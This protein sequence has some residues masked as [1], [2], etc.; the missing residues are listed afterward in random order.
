LAYFSP[1]VDSA[2]LH[3]PA[4]LDIRDD[5]IAQAK[6]I[7]GS[8]IYLGNDSLDYQ[9]ISA[10]ALKYSD[11]L[12]AVQLAYNN[13]SPS[14][15][16]G[17]GLDGIVKLNGIK[18]KIASYSTCVVT[19][20]G[21]AG[22][23]ILNGAVSDISGNIWDLPVAVTIG[24]SG[25]VD[26]VAT[27][28][29]IGAITAQRG[30][31]SNISTPTYGWI[32]VTNNVAAVVG[33]PVE[34]D[35]QLK[36]RQAISTE[37]PSQTLLQGTNAGVASVTGVSRYKTYENDT[38]EFDY[39]GLP[40]H[41]V[42]VVAEGGSD[43]DIA[44]QIYARKNIGCY[45]NGTTAVDIPDQY[46]VT[47]IRFYKPTYLPIF[48]TL[49]VHALAGYTSATT[50]NIK[51]AI[52]SYLNSLQIGESLT[53]SAVWATAMSATPNLKQPI[54]SLRSVLV[55]TNSVLQGTSD[56]YAAFNQVTQNDIANIV[57]NVV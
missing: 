5:L 34:E 52:N 14:T 57:V 2:G 35:S 1:Y 37:L 41:S 15:A 19:I 38:S 8:D 43:S 18:R 25:T 9:L 28:R 31:I 56:I 39:N 29:V 11:D 7:Y 36:S 30:N 26:A 47:T 55:G 13:R 22:I 45:T 40:P 44:Q 32:S 53:I 27:C 23:T 17:S 33:L 20:T 4:Y 42:T 54:F 16:K 6:A 12:Q 50:D 24:I 51:S 21:T 48:C 46:G 10:L 49:T 3:I